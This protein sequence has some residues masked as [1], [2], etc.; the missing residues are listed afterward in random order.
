MLLKKGTCNAGERAI[1]STIHDDLIQLT[2]HLKFK[3]V[4]QIKSGCGLCVEQAISRIE[5]IIS[6]L[7][8]P[9]RIENEDVPE[10]IVKT[11]KK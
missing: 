2:P 8:T 6:L 4:G 3:K 7:S 11:K 1:L 10:V 5:F 9:E